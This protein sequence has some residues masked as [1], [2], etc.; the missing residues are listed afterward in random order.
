MPLR[1]DAMYAEGG[2]PSIPPEKPLR[3][4]RLQMLYSVPSERQVVERVRAPGLVSDE[5][6]TVDGTLLDA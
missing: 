6:F 3:V 2:R 5:H 4:Q 1:F